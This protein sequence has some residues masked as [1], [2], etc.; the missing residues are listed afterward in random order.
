[1]ATSERR[2]DQARLGELEGG[3]ARATRSCASY[4]FGD[5]AGSV[6]LRRRADAD[7]AEEMNHHPDLADPAG[8]R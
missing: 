5:F 2:R 3:R 7:A 6:K 4:K 8:T 1:M